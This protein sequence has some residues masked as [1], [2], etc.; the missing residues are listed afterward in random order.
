MTEARAI[1]NQ[2]AQRADVFAD[3][4]I[5]GQADADGQE[6]RFVPFAVFPEAS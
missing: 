3:V 2:E 6:A 1:G 5:A 4:D